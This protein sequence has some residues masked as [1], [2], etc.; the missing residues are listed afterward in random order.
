M[1]AKAL[2]IFSDLSADDGTLKLLKSG[3]APHELLFPA[4]PAASVLSSSEPDPALVE[5]DIAF[6]QPN[7]AAVLQASRLRWLQ[8][9]SAGYTRYD[10]AEFRNAA[11]KRK[12]V[13]TNSSTVYAES[14]A[15]HALAFMLAQA[16]RLPDAL[17]AGAAGDSLAWLQLR[18]SSVLLREQNVLILGFG[19]IARNL[20]ALLQPLRMHVVALRRKAV[21]DEA[22]PIVT[23]ADLPQALAKADHVINLLPANPSSVQFMS[24]SQ[25][26]AMKRGSVFYNIGRG[27]TVDQDALLAALNSGHLAAAWLDVTEPEPLPPEH[28]LFST[29]NCYITPHVAGGQR[30]ELEMLVRHFLQNFSCFL[31]RA[32]LHDRIM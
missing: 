26:A 5:A 12:L 32:P 25:F 4:K 7:A 31:S 23:A 14:C 24:T 19:S 3:V 16:R 27:A 15:E 17:R 2:K 6:G 30:N 28:P 10:T 21:G 29:R 11:A 18:D 13:V 20:I 9:S 22:V 8:I 1:P